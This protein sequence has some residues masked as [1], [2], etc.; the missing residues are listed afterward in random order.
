MG[1]TTC[2]HFYSFGLIFLGLRYQKNLNDN[3]ILNFISILRIEIFFEL[4]FL[5][6]NCSSVTRS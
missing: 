5:V 2:L 6:I 4:S 1:F 3:F